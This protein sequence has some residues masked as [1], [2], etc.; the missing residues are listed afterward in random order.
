MNPLSQQQHSVASIGSLL[1]GLQ[2][3]KDHSTQSH[4]T[5]GQSNSGLQQGLS[6]LHNPGSVPGRTPY[7]PNTLTT[8]LHDRDSGIPKP[9]LQ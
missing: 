2:A 4:G 3:Q 7:T 5:S 1:G 8:P 6:D 9:Q